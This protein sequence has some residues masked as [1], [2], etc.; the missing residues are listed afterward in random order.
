MAE[1]SARP[2]KV[3]I[4][5]AG[6]TGLTLALVLAR[7]GISVRIIEKQSARS[8]K[9]RAL[10][11]HAGSLELFDALLGDSVSKAMIASGHVAHEITLG[12]EG[13]KTAVASL[14]RVPSRYNFVL[15]LAQSETERFLEDELL[16][17][18]VAV[19]RR[20][21]FAGLEEFSEAVRVELRDDGG[22]TESVRADF[23]V[24]CDGSHSGVRESLGLTFT[25][26]QYPGAFMLADLTLEWP[27]NYEGVRTFVTRKGASA[28]FPFKEKGRYRMVVVPREGSAF[29]TA[30]E[31]TLADFQRWVDEV[32]RQPIKLRDPTWI[33][34]FRIHRRI[35]NSYG[36]HRVFLAG[37]AAHIHSPVG[38]QGMNIGIHDAVNLGRRIADVLRERAPMTTLEGYERERRPVAEW[39]SRITGFVLRTATRPES[40]LTGL[41]VR[42]VLPFFA[43]LRFLQGILARAISEVGPARR[44]IAR[45]RRE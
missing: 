2:P 39:V 17:R 11:V 14:D 18:G 8:D 42:F 23:V 22:K 24:G 40:P 4:V 16:R 45:L 25:G 43:N 41:V 3:L 36:R 9:S 35:A 19:E 28:F 6:P 27:W 32:L 5:G 12:F 31:P 37:D 38:G 34:G 21:E 44:E 1:L 33:T 7:A 20:K 30:S 10:G 13:G 15:I 26:V 29:T